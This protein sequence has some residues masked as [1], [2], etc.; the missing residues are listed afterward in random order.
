MKEFSKVTLCIAAIGMPIA[1]SELMINHED[2]TSF[3]AYVGFTLLLFFLYSRTYPNEG[4]S[5]TSPYIRQKNELWLILFTG[6][7]FHL[8]AITIPFT[9][10]HSLKPFYS[11]RADKY[12]YPDMNSEVFVKALVISVVFFLISRSLIAVLHIFLETDS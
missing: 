12:N 4:G 7:L 6:G 2:R 1:F 5:M 8:F 10:L 9:V 11:H 3:F